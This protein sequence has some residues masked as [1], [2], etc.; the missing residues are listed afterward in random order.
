M[1]HSSKKVIRVPLLKYWYLGSFASDY[2]P[3]LDNDTFA[4]ITTQSSKMQG[5]HCIMNATF[6][7]KL[8]FADSL[9]RK[10]YSFSEQ[11]YKQTNKPRFT[12]ITSQRLQFLQDKCS[13][14]SLEIPRR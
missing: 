13:F 14:S 1:L 9:G 2:V 12:T 4:M 6:C 7:R 8:Y 10:L 5:E 3:T 11:Q